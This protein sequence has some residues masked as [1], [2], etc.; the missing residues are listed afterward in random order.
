MKGTED[1]ARFFTVLNWL[2]TRMAA[3]GGLPKKVDASLQADYYEA[4]EDLRIERIEWGAKHLFKTEVFFPMPKDL[5]AAANLAPSSVLAAIQ[6]KEQVAIPEFT[7]QQHI[8]A[9]NELEKIINGFGLSKGLCQ[10]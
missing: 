6:M 3:V 5:R 7:E 2:A 8:D 4:L 10:I 1:K 9:A